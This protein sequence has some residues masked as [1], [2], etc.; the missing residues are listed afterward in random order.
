MNTP[1]NVRPWGRYDILDCGDGYQVKRITVNPGGRLS[2]QRHEMREEYWVILS[3]RV[4]FTL[5]DVETEHGPGAVL[6]IPIRSK[7]RLAC[8]SDTPAVF[9]EVQRG[10][11]L[12]E[13]DIERFSDDYGREGTTS[14]HG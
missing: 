2:Y 14:P 7:H 12:G 5:D 1:E 11:Y 13:D 4:Q 3:G 9:I 8:I 10:D 6:I